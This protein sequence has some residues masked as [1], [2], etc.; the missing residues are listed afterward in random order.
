MKLLKIIAFSALFAMS[1]MAFAVPITGEIGFSGDNTIVT[2]T[3]YSDATE[4]SFSDVVVGSGA[5]G[6][7]AE[8][9]LTSGTSAT[10]SNLVIDPFAPQGLW[11]AG[12]FSFSTN[13]LDVDF[14]N[15]ATMTLS[16]V[17][18]VSGN[19]F[20]ATE[21]SW[22]MSANQLTFSA[23]TITADP[24]PVPAPGLLALVGLGLIGIG[25]SRRL[26]KK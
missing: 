10:F 17:G 24:S 21:G 4:L 23:F 1:S 18:T 12:G 19:G 2:G 16:G 11:E 3:D 25:I 14:Q 15:A 6:S 26:K 22:S 5:T 9:G 7:F 13:T 8:A 20:D